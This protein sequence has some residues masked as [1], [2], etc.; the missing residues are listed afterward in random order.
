MTPNQRRNLR[1]S[2]VDEVFEELVQRHHDRVLQQLRLDVEDFIAPD[3]LDENQIPSKTVLNNNSKSSFRS[4]STSSPMTRLKKCESMDF[5]DAAS[6]SSSS[7]FN[8]KSKEGKDRYKKNSSNSTNK[9]GKSS[10]LKEGFKLSFLSSAKKYGEAINKKYFARQSRNKDTITQNNVASQE[11]KGTVKMRE[12]SSSKANRRPLSAMLLSSSMSKSSNLVSQDPNV[13]N[14][15]RNKDHFEYHQQSISITD[16]ILTKHATSDKKKELSRSKSTG[17]TLARRNSDCDFMDS[18]EEEPTKRVQ[19]SKII[20]S[21][22]EQLNDNDVIDDDFSDNYESDVREPV[23][24][25]IS[26]NLN[27][28]IDSNQDNKIERNKIRVLY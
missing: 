10:D 1:K 8:S 22:L 5:K 23:N 16:N 21:F 17:I 18:D 20:A 2:L 4:S 7:S 9:K 28:N 13:N 26:T 6:L 19:R 15:T 12:K 14:M 27:N 24:N 25:N 3:D 11:S